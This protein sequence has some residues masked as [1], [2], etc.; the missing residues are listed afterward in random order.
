MKCRRNRHRTQRVKSL[1]D[2][3]L[4]ECGSITIR[5]IR[6]S[7]R[8]QNSALQQLSG[9]PVLKMM[10]FANCRP[11]QCRSH[12]LKCPP[13]LQ[14]RVPF[15]RA[16]Y[17]CKTWLSLLQMQSKLVELSVTSC[18]RYTILLTIVFSDDLISIHLLSTFRT[19]Q[20]R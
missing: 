8:P 18:L 3:L 7:S 15:G 10:R 9:R 2:P 16:L 14:H 5:P 19:S 11:L 13:V 17:L 4:N 20:V 12:P 1:R 6:Y